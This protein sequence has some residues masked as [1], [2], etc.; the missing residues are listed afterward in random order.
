MY[1]SFE[2]AHIRLSEEE[3]PVEVWQVDGVHVNHVDVPGKDIV[4]TVVIGVKLQP[5]AHHGEVFKELTAKSTGPN[6]QDFDVLEEKWQDVG[7]RSVWWRCQRASPL[8]HL[9]CKI[10]NCICLDVFV[11]FANAFVEID[12]WF[13]TFQLELK[14]NLWNMTPS[15]RPV[16]W[17]GIH[18]HLI[19]KG[20]HSIQNMTHNISRGTY[21]FLVF[22][23]LS[24]LSIFVT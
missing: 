7:R 4:T 19:L 8:E 20:S 10:S 1:L 21:I 12:S 13:R 15:A 2:F 22:V 17:R 11:H 3:L 24:N 16:Y 5:E 6:D 23:I 18:L 14:S 9:F